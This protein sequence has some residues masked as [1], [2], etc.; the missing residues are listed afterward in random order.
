MVSGPEMARLIGEFEGS[1]KKKQD[2]DRCHHEQ[3][4]HV[5]TAF[6]RDVQALSRAIEEMG[7][8]FCESSSDLLVLDSRNIADAAVVDTV[9]QIEKLGLDQYEAYVEERLVNQTKPITDPLKRNNLHLF[10]RPPVRE[11]SSKQIQLSTLKNNCLL[12][13]RLYILPPR[14][15]MVILM[16]SSSTKTRPVHQHLHR[17][18]Y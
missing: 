9:H 4:K 14:Y 7:N 13:S 10:S 11:K 2:K 3:K 6:A 15:A 8:P 18:V 12:F 5:Q 16:S 1:T 17:W